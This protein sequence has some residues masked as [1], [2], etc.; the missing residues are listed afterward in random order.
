MPPKPRESKYANMIHPTLDSQKVPIGDLK[1]YGR[2]PRRGDVEMIRQSLLKNGQYR[3]IV[4]RVGT[5]EVLAGNHTLKAARSLD[6]KEIATSWVE[7]DDDEA[8][9]IVL[10]DN[11]ANDMAGYDNDELLSILQARQELGRSLEGTGYTDER[12]AQLAKDVL[13][14]DAGGPPDEGEAPISNLG[15]VWGVMVTCE[16]EAQQRKVLQQLDAEG[17]Q[18]RAVVL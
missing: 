9:R 14:A 4:S 5:N 18:V 11:A 1:H 10:V 8:E 17:L 6:W 2:N 12:I 16:S 15:T 13:D 3:S 7:V